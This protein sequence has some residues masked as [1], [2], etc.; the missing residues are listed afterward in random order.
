[1]DR[2]RKGGVAI[3]DSKRAYPRVI[4][5]DGKPTQDD[6]QKIRKIL[7]ERRRQREEKAPAR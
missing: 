7:D 5:V 1:M 4:H 2:H 6:V 3:M